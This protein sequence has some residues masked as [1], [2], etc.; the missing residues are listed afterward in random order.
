MNW[1]LTR[2]CRPGRCCAAAAPAAAEGELNIF[3]WGNYTSPELIKKFEEAYN[4]KVTVTDYDSNDTA[5]AK[6]RA[7]G[8]GFD[9]VVPSANFVPIWISEGLLLESAPRPDGELQERRPALGRRAP[10]IRAATTPCRG[11]GARPASSSTPRVYKGDINTS[12]IFLDPPAEL[13]GKINVVPEMNDVMF[14]AIMYVGG[15]PCTDDKEVLKKVRDKLMAAK[16]KWIVDGLRR[17]SRSSPAATIGAGVQL[18]RRHLA[19]A[20]CRTRTCSSAIPRKA[21]RS[22]WT[23]SRSSRTPRTSRTPSCS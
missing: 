10:G 13:V 1:K 15:E 18:E 4:V 5:L 9:I 7:G 21:S 8:H 16:P 22:G 20:R 12:A 3:N 17:A 2:R 11:S 6:V 23:A 14:A 19:L